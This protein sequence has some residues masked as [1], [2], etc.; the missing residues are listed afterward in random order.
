MSTR[1]PAHVKRTVVTA[2]ERNDWREAP[3]PGA[4]QWRGVGGTGRFPQAF[5]ERHAFGAI[6]FHSCDDLLNTIATGRRWTV[7]LF[8]AFEG[9]RRRP[10][11]LPPCLFMSRPPARPAGGG[12]TWRGAQ[13]G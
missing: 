13:G 5:S 6:E 9:A 8:K 11:T 3:V 12:G 7:P 10:A 4:D 2:K 1:W